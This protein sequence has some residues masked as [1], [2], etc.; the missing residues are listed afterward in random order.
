V[1]LTSL[2]KDKEAVVEHPTRVRIDESK[3]AE[4]PS[5]STKADARRVT[6]LIISTI[7]G[8]AR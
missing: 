3:A 4:I 2:Y 8:D 6:A 1:R 5:T 7:L